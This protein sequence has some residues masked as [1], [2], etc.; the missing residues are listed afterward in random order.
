MLKRLRKE[1]ARLE[2]ASPWTVLGIPPTEDADAIAQA[3][4]RMKHRYGRI[5]RDD[6]FSDA[7]ADMARALVNRVGLAAEEARKPRP[8]P[9]A[10][11][12][13]S[14]EARAFEA[15]LAAMRVGDWP[16]AVR[17][18]RT[19]HN[20]R[21]DV[22]QYMAHLGWALFN[23]TSRGDARLQEALEVLELADS[24]DDTLADGQLW[25]GLVELAS[26]EL[27]RAHARLK[28]LKARAPDHPGVDDAL[29]KVETALDEAVEMESFEDEEGGA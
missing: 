28:R 11:G 8:P 15:G 26:E 25:L 4:K 16:R 20:T 27:E 24:W 21:I 23:D 14:N 9:P 1:T 17:G 18:F 3:E 6:R 12:P 22:P 19:A 5:A 10:D 29:Q 13:E 7:I 2:G